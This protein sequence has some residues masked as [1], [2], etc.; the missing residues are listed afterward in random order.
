MMDGSKIKLANGL[1]DLVSLAGWYSLAVTSNG[2]V[3]N[4]RNGRTYYGLTNIAGVSAPRADHGNLVAL[5]RDGTVVESTLRDGEPLIP[6]GVSKV[7]AVA[8]GG[9]QKLALKSDG[10]VFAWGSYTNMPSMLTNVVAISAGDFHSLALM[11]N[12]T[13]RAWGNNQRSNVPDGLTDVIAIAAGD[14]FSLAITTN[15]AVADRF[16]R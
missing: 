14:D 6:V 12:G 3:V 10:T 15:A 4:L 1:R 5:R 8:A 11:K 7:V 16:K 2:T 13:V 9:W